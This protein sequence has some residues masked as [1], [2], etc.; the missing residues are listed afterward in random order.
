MIIT[1]IGNVS[2]DLLKRA[3]HNSTVKSGQPASKGEF[4]K[5]ASMVNIR[6]I[7]DIIDDDHDDVSSDGI[8]DFVEYKDSNDNTSIVS[9]NMENEIRNE[10]ISSNAPIPPTEIFNRWVVICQ[11]E[12]RNTQEAIIEKAKWI[13]VMKHELT[14]PKTFTYVNILTSSRCFIVIVII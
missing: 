3:A 7:N 4:K 1:L 5:L 14:N 11:G 13:A 10:L 6:D 9:T 8:S 2:L 12:Y